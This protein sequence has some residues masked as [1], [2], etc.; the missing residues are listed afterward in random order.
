M[1][2]PG[3]AE[4]MKLRRGLT[5][6]LKRLH[7][8]LGRADFLWLSNMPKSSL[9]DIRDGTRTPSVDFCLKHLRELKVPVTV[10]IGDLTITL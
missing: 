10:M 8:E 2:S 5:S 6:H 9:Q 1:S 3:D 7:T 4:I